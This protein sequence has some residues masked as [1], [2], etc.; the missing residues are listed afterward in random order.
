MMGTNRLSIADMRV[1]LTAMS[2]TDVASQDKIITA[3]GNSVV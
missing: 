2:I 3:L 1:K